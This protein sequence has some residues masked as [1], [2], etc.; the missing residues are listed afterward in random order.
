MNGIRKGYYVCKSVVL[1]QKTDGNLYKPTKE[2]IKLLSDY[3]YYAHIEMEGVTPITKEISTE[4]VER[5][6]SS[7]KIY[8]WKNK[9]NIIVSICYY[10]IIENKEELCGVYTHPKYRRKNYA[11][12]LVYNITKELL[13][14]NFIPFLYTNYDYKPSNKTYIN[15]GYELKKVI[16]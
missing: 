5:L 11:S 13:D 6:L 1:P 2:D 15:V 8:C 14:K 16:E 3:W 9:N 12:N 7:N 4:N 10:K